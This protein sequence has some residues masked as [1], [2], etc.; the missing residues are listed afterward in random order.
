MADLDGNTDVK[1]FLDYQMRLSIAAPLTISISPLFFIKN[2][3]KVNNWNTKKWQNHSKKMTKSFPPQKKKDYHPRKHNTCSV[4]LSTRIFCWKEAIQV[5][6]ISIPAKASET[7]ILEDNKTTPEFSPYKTS[8][9][10]HNQKLKYQIHLFNHES[11]TNIF[12]IPSSKI[13]LFH[14]KLP[15][16]RI[17]SIMPSSESLQNF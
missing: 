3:T 7:E 14:P 11:F 6:A 2:C 5:A 13:P 8:P 17:Y 1:W 15:I 12:P 9:Q 10:F 4:S 16:M